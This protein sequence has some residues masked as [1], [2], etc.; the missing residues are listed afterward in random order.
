VR[1]GEGGGIGVREG[2]QGGHLPPKI[3]ENSGRCAA[4]ILAD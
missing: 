2:G 1:W 3:P 4:Q